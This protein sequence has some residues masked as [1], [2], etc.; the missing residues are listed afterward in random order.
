MS[1]VNV[2]VNGESFIVDAPNKSTA[3]AY[4][5]RQIKVEVLEATAK[6]VTDFVLSGKEIV[7]LEVGLPNAEAETET[8]TET[9]A[10]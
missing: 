6:E 4:G 2:K 9:D 8:E 7:K 10:E 5:R 3:K 1:L